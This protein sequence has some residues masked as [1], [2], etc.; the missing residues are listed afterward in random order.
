MAI[1]YLVGAGSFILRGFYPANGDFVIAADDGY[2]AL[3]SHGFTPD[4]LVGDFDSL[5]QIPPGIPCK[6][7]SSEKNDTD[8]A[9]A[10]SEGMARGYRTFSLYGASGGREDHTHANLQLLGGASKKGCA[11]KMVCPEYDVY[12]ITDETLR[13]PKHVSGTIVSVFCHGDRAEGVTLEGL[14]YP[15]TDA[16]LSC[17]RPLGVSNET[18]GG[19]ALI[20]VRSGTLLVYVLLQ[21][22]DGEGVRGESDRP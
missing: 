3:K 1:C 19:E 2:S 22:A 7:Y 9:L 18:A 11:C 10:L 17:D 16:V 14:K 12:A 20:S 13:L 8:L 15:L 5:K 4:L 6:A 21:S